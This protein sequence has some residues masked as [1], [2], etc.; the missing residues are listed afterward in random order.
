MGYRSDVLLALKDERFSELIKT[1][2]DRVA[3]NFIDGSKIHECN[4]WKLV[5]F[6]D[7]KWYDDYPEVKAVNE[8]IEELEDLNQDDYSYHVLGEDD[9]D[10]TSKGTW[11]TPFNIRLNRS[12]DFDF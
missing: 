10:Y 12:L 6:H 1:M 9:N 2:E 5:E 4:G 11:E 3:A 7:V 8:F